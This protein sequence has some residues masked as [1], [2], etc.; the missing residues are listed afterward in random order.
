MESLNKFKI[1][2]ICVVAMFVFAIA[3]IYSNTKDASMDK[4][5]VKTEDINREEPEDTAIS[6]ANEDDYSTQIKV[7]NGRIDELNERVDKTVERQSNK[8]NCKV[9]GIMTKDG[10]TELSSDDAI[11][12]AKNNGNDIIISCSL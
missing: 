11:Q 10:L 9:M 12:E 1:L 4:T 2:T 5:M 3:A 7:L 6:G 8:L